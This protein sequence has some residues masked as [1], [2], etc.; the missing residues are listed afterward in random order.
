[1]DPE[2]EEA[3]AL[4][5]PLEAFDRGEAPEA[6]LGGAP[7]PLDALEP[8]GGAPS[9]RPTAQL[10]RAAISAQLTPLNVRSPRRWREW[11]VMG[12]LLVAAGLASGAIYRLI[13]PGS[14]EGHQYGMVLQV[15]PTDDLEVF[16]DGNLVGRQGPLLL[17]GLEPH[18]SYEVRVDR[19]GYRTHQQHVVL[20]TPALQE[21]RVDLVPAAAGFVLARLQVTPS[22]ADVYVDEAF[23]EPAR[24][25]SG[26]RLLV[27]RSVS[28][29]IRREGYESQEHLV[30]PRG[31]AQVLRYDLKRLTD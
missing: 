27:G 24:R 29:A 8:L 3:T 1:M 21:I 2:E 4:W 23:V 7:D 22:D 28:I 31:G 12:A 19:E 20:T 16:L 17:R 9:N 18:V 30:L 26:V 10:E 11:L 5:A 25:L 15:T 6:W 13:A 14:T